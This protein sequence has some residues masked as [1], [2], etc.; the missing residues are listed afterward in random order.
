MRSLSEMRRMRARELVQ[1]ALELRVLAWLLPLVVFWLVRRT[2]DDLLQQGIGIVIAAGLLVLVIRNA[3]K[4]VLFLVGFI[5]FQTI[6][7]AWLY[8][9]GMPA[10]ILRNAAGYRDV[11]VVGVLV[12]GF[13]RMRDHGENLDLID[14]AALAFIVINVLYMVFPHFFVRINDPFA[15]GKP[16]DLHARSLAMRVNCAPIVLLIGAR[17]LRPDDRF[18]ARLLQL[19]LTVGLIVAAVTIFEFSFSDTWNTFGTQIIRLPYYEYDVL[20]VIARSSF[21][22]RSYM[23]I[24]GKVLTRPGSVFFDPLQNGFFL[25]IPFAVAV[26][27]AVRKALTRAYLVLPVLALAVLFTYVRTAALGALIIGALALRTRGRQ[28]VRFGIIFGAALVFL[29]MVAFSTG[30]ATRVANKGGETSN[31]GHVT[32]TQRGWSALFK[33]PLGRGLGN[34]AGIGDRFKS[35]A[36]LTA[37]N[38]YLQIGNEIG[39]PAMLLFATILIATLLRLRRYSARLSAGPPPGRSARRDAT[40]AALMCGAALAVGGFFLHVWLGVPTAL[41]FWGLAGLAMT[42]ERDVGA[43]GSVPRQAKRS[44]SVARSLAN[45]G[46]G[47]FPLGS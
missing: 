42:G 13:R 8:K 20:Q 31:S 2:P 43:A 5:P 28:R 27:L 14:K 41:T 38:A 11:I 21:D 40:E 16:P 47:P 19:I 12:A 45:A 15:V 4:S 18:K 35:Q 17:H 29:T 22:V 1:R 37:E 10:N 46:A 9:M 23:S 25:L 34:V 26:Q 30:F 3:E 32:E 39:V 44:P 6:V 24:S 36:K 33:T 7:F